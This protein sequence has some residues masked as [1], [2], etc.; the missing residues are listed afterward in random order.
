M[1][2][3]ETKVVSCYSRTYS[4]LRLYR[5]RRGSHKRMSST[6]P[7]VGGTAGFHKLSPGR[8]SHPSARIC[9]SLWPR[10][11]R[12][13]LSVGRWS[14]VAEV[15]RP[16]SLASGRLLLPRP[17]SISSQTLRSGYRNMARTI[18]PSVA[19]DQPS[20][21]EARP[22]MSR[23]TV[24]LDAPL[25]GITLPTT[26]S[27]AEPH[28]AHPPRVERVWIPRAIALS[29]RRRVFA[30]HLALQQALLQTDSS[31]KQSE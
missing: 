10:A 7:T 22:G 27:N 6:D 24:L 19:L 18:V 9:G 5:Q 13:S 23:Q 25:F 3:K 4:A 21:F 29:D 26:P 17:Y 12:L 28:V 20:P 14:K 8:T 16:C 11:M 30:C 1:L 15:K 2:P 31:P